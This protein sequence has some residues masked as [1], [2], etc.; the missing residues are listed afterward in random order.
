MLFE[1]NSILSVFP[2]E[3]VNSTIPSQE[4]NLSALKSKNSTCQ[5]PGH[6]ENS[7]AGLSSLKRQ[8]A[9]ELEMKINPNNTAADFV[10]VMSSH[11]RV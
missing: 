1:K 6:S 11:K 10:F 3:S 2:F 5:K 7:I 9:R 8:P 4:L